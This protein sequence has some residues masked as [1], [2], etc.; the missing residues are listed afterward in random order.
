MR[1]VSKL[2]PAS[3]MKLVISSIGVLALVLFTS[4]VVFEST[5]AEVII[6]NNGEEKK[7]KTHKNTVGEILDQEGIEVG[8]HDALSHNLDADIEDGMKIDYESAKRLTLEIDGKVHTYYSTA[9]TLKEFLE[10]Q[11]L[12]FSKD[13]EVSL[14]D[15]DILKDGQE[16]KV[17]KAFEVTVND[18]GE[19][20]ASKVTG[21]TV[22]NLLEKSEIELNDLDKI[23]PSLDD[24]VTKD[25]VITITRVEKK[26]E[27]VVE[28]VAFDTETKED[29]SLEKGKE[30]VVTEGEKGKVH[31]T[32][33]VTLENG[34][35]VDRKLLDE[36]I[37]E[38]KVNRVV[39][40]GTKEPAQVVSE[41]S[42]SSSSNNNASSDKTITMTASA[43][44]A[45]CNGCSGY[46]TT[47][48]N[49]KDNPNN[50]VIAVDPNV[51][52]LGTKVWVEGYGE[53]IAGDTGGNINGNRI[54]VHVPDKSKAYSWGVRDVQVKILD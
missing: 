53:A 9:Q 37:Q 28:E 13:D 32:F 54:D 22:Q 25:T 48:I 50:K 39:A 21:G 4:M 15:N 31:K 11:S 49:L 44:T 17:K 41:T 35:E 10:E 27:K 7:I 18:G 19:E 3:K 36:A 38:K 40:V 33:E 47:G 24:V 14:Q 20:K 45:S 23:S 2:L 43:F 1:F 42:T 52:P 16:I 12:S 26:K 46:T 51:I 29:S 8:D 5:K 30:K 34:E 6:T